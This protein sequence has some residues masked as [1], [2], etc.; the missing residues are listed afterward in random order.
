MKASLL[1]ERR[2][3]QMDTLGWPELLV[4]GLVFVLLFGTK[5][6]PELAKGLGEGIRNFK[7]SLKG[8]VQ[9]VKNEVEKI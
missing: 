5:K 1:D 7:T 6:I 9:D 4:I 3:A 8:E 2:S